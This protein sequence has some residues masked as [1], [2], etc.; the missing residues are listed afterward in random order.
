MPE[1]DFSTIAFSVEEGELVVRAVAR[2]SGAAYRHACDLASFEQVARAIDGAAPDG[3]TREQI[4]AAIVLGERRARASRIFVSFRRSMT[5][6][7]AI[8]NMNITPWIKGHS[9]APWGISC[10]WSNSARR[11]VTKA[12]STTSE[13]IHA[14]RALSLPMMRTVN[15]RAA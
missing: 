9:A 6:N 7:D 15:K 13:I 10:G 12:R 2:R 4:Q 3:L 1:T 8:T 14:A 11:C 5:N